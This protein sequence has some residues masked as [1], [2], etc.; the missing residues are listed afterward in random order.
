MT[1]AWREGRFEVAEHSQPLLLSNLG[2]RGAGG[3]QGGEGKQT[4][5]G[6]QVF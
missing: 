6:G 1:E 4:G 2:G 5:G 3:K